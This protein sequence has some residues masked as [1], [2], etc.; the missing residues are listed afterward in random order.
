MFEYKLWFV[1]LPLA[2]IISHLLNLTLLASSFQRPAYKISIVNRMKINIVIFLIN[3]Y[4]KGNQNF[5]IISDSTLNLVN[6]VN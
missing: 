2:P 1:T 5:R 6:P 3:G 4:F